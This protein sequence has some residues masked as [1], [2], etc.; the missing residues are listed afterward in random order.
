LLTSVITISSI[1]FTSISIEKVRCDL[2]DALIFSCFFVLS[3]TTFRWFRFDAVSS[4]LTKL[5][6]NN[7]AIHVL[8]EFPAYWK[9]LWASVVKYRPSFGTRP[10]RAC[11]D[12]DGDIKRLIVL[13]DP[14]NQY[15]IFD[16]NGNVSIT[17]KFQCDGMPDFTPFHLLQW[18]VADILQS[19]N[20][21]RGGKEPR[22]LLGMISNSELCRRVNSR[23]VRTSNWS[24][25]IKDRKKRVHWLFQITLGM[26]CIFCI[27]IA[28]FRLF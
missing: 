21:L 25:C 22:S 8:G 28:I 16:I 17:V 23:A 7:T 13:E 27:S 10:H 4:I 9:D 1:H 14:S 20:M 3:I 2:I 11:F 24:C 19:Y 12:K 6:S 5:S 26:S 15:Y 18:I